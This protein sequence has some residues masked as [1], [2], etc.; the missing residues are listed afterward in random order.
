MQVPTQEA[1]AVKWGGKERADSAV[2]FLLLARAGLDVLRNLP[3]GVLGQV[4][5]EVVEEVNDLLVA[6][7]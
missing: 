4:V 3:H 2:V 5:F 1:R 6:L 7:E